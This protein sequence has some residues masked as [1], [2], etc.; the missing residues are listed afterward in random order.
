M[1]ELQEALDFKEERSLR[2]AELTSAIEKGNGHTT[3]VIPIRFERNITAGEPHLRNIVIT[4]R[5]ELERT[6]RKAIRKGILPESSE[7]E[8]M[9]PEEAWERIGRWNSLSTRELR[10][11]RP[12]RRSDTTRY[13]SSYYSYRNRLTSGGCYSLLTTKKRIFV[14]RH[15]IAVPLQIV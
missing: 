13:S 8:I 4:S 1:Q 10:L 5:E 3:D 9:K 15:D 2:L 7:G 11:F 12:F 6:L 14:I